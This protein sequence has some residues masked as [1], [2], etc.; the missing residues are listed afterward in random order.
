M[1]SLLYDASNAVERLVDK[2]VVALL[3]EVERE[4][5]VVDGIKEERHL[6]D[7]AAVS[8]VEHK[9]YDTEYGCRAEY[10][11]DDVRVHIS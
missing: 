11:D 9:A 8:S 2:S 4:V 5:E 10:G 7:G 3:W 6:S 1:S